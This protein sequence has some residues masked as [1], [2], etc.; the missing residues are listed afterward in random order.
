MDELSPSEIMQLASQLRSPKGSAGINVGHKMHE[1][2]I[3][4]IL[5]TVQALDLTEGD[6]ILELG[7]GNAAHVAQLLGRETNIQYTSLDISQTMQEEAQRINAD[8]IK[9]GKAAFHLYD[10]HQMSFE[11]NQFDTIMTVN[12]IYFWEQPVELLNE[13]H[14]VLKPNGRCSICFAEKSFMKDLPFAQYG[15]QLY[16]TDDVKTLAEQSHFQ[17]IDIQ[18]QTE[19]V[20]S[21]DGTD[22]ERKFTVITLKA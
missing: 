18:N 21:K 11:D 19:Q 17:I 9:E 12:T 10:G 16:S 20:E 5:M 1:T 15:F 6:H 3:N 22:V 8:L 13:A 7:P 14:R 4:M 2:N